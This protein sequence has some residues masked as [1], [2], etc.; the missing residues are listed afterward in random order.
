MEI[1]TLNDVREVLNSIP[2][3]N[4]GGCGI[5]ALSMYL[6]LKKYDKI[7]PDFKF[8]LGFRS[9]NKNGYENAVSNFVKKENSQLYAPSHVVIFINGKYIDSD[10][11]ITNL[12]DEYRYT[13]SIG[14]NTKNLINLINGINWNRDFDRKKYIPYIESKLG[15]KFPKRIK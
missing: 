5:S 10:E 9:C 1:K 11:T 13:L 8:Y 3:I 7:P 12:D 15:I 6:W 14:K 2:T 4:F